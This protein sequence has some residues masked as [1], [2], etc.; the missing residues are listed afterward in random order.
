MN[1]KE[2]LV[3]ENIYRDAHNLKTVEIEKMLGRCEL[4]PLGNYD[5]FSECTKEE[6]DAWNYLEHFCFD[7]P[8]T[9]SGEELANKQ[10]F[11]EG[12]EFALS[13]MGIKEFRY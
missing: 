12:V 7:E 11:L 2:K 5:K 1:N 4:E 9:N 8:Y 3:L 13:K 6:Q 10:G